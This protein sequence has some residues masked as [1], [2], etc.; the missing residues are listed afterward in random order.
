MAHNVEELPRLEPRAEATQL[1]ANTPPMTLQPGLDPTGPSWI[2]YS[3]A[4]LW[5]PMPDIPT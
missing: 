2:G 1:A 4:D 3:L 5:R